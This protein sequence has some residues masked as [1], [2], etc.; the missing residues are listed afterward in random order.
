MRLFSDY[1][2]ESKGGA[3][4]QKQTAQAPLSQ[5][6]GCDSEGRPL[7]KLD[8]LPH[9]TPFHPRRQFES[10]STS[11]ACMKK[12]AKENEGKKKENSKKLTH[13]PVR[14]LED[15]LRKSSSK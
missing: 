5:W 3:D 13:L 14:R 10:P 6:W 8:P 11:K 12:K 4:R 15:G 2:S 1:W 7:N 9:R